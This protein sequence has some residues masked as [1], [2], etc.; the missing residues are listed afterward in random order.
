MAY[1]KTKLFEVPKISDRVTFIYVEHAKINCVDGAVTVAESRGIV[2]IPAAIIG[3]LLL[4]P[5]TDISHRAMVL[6]GESGASVAWVGEY[7]IRNYAHGRSLSHSSRFLEVQ[8]NLVSNT[9]TR[10]RV[11]REMYQ[12]RFPNE[13]VSALTMQQLRAKEGARIRK[14]YRN[15]SEEYHVQWDGRTYDPDNYEGGDPVNQALSS[16]NVAL[17]GLTYSAVAAMGM[18][19]GLGFVHTGHDLSFV[20]EIAAPL[21]SKKLGRPPI[22]PVIL[23]KY[24]LVGFLYGIP[25]ERQIELRI[26]TDIALRW[27]LGLDLFDHVPDHSTISQLRRRKPAFRNV[28]RRLFEEVV[29]QCIEKGLVSGR[30]VA[31]DST[32]VKANASLASEELVEVT[33]SPA[34]YWERLNAYEQEAAAELHRKCGKTPKRKRSKPL[35]RRIYRSRKRISR[36]DPEAGHMNRPGKPVGQYYLSHQTLDT[37]HGI[38]LDVAVTAGDVNDATPYLDQ[39]ERVNNSVIPIQTA[40]ADAAYDFPLAHRVLDDIGIAFFVRPQLQHDIAQTQIQRS[41]FRYEETIDAYIC[42]SGN[43][44]PLKNLH[45][46]SGGLSWLYRPNRKD[47]LSCPL[48]ERCMTSS[49]LVRTIS[50]SYFRQAVEKNLSRRDDPA[51][52][53]ALRKRQIWCEGTFA[54]Q[55]RGHNLTRI[56]RR[57]LEAAEDHCLLSATVMNLI[58]MIK[59]MG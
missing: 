3:I 56:L 42:P 19:A 48:R 26:Q 18:S 44:L 6:L 59:A 34:A 43:L 11:A 45:R 7:G 30:V 9:R 41:A 10:L 4:G 49:G 17:Y 28:F 39:I 15:M 46:T 47:C 5:G 29:R 12:M 27:Y 21:Y 57:G 22:D 2:R 54:A 40:T 1:N 35:K 23:V 16:A 24:L 58:R 33:E 31:T 36:T 20:Y 25:S 14:L 8:A 51:Y 38:I 55:K 50:H 52:K 32:H 13:D 37:D 53:D